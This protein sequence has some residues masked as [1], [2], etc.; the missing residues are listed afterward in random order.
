VSRP[1]VTD[2]EIL[3]SRGECTWLHSWPKHSHGPP[4]WRITGM[5]VHEHI[6]T[7]YTCDGCK[8]RA[9]SL[10]PVPG[11]NCGPCFGLGTYDRHLCRVGGI[12]ITPLASIQA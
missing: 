10:H 7:M 2:P 9:G 8:E 1:H 4:S 11:L 5:C 6:S 12:E 3:L